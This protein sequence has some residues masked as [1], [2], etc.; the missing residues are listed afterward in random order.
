MALDRS[1]FK[2][3]AIGGPATLYEVTDLRE[4]LRTAIS[5]GQ[6]L[7]LDLRGSGKWDLAGLQLL[8]SCIRTGRSQGREIRLVNVPSTCA[9][10]AA[11]S[12]LSAWLE[13]V[14]E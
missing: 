14:S 5:A 11:R 7:H 13:S 1:E 3:V 4:V 8:I 10:I 6:N 9:E 2:T 12:G